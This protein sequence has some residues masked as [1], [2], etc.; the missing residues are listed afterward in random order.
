MTGVQTWL[1]RSVL[2]AHAGAQFSTFKKDITDL[3]VV[4]LSPITAKMRELMTNPDEIDRLLAKGAER[5]NALADQ[6]MR[7]VR[8]IVGLWSRK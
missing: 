1:F 7:E 2:T 5:A 3:A 6:H 8:D 4:K